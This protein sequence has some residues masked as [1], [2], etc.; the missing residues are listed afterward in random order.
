[1]T[2]NSANVELAPNHR[3]AESLCMCIHQVANVLQVSSTDENAYY[4]AGKTLA[5]EVLLLITV[6]ANSEEGNAKIIV[7]CEKLVIGSMMT[8]DIQHILSK[9][10]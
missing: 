1:M 8:K 7:N 5:S 10:A 3:T 6:Q 9:P 2:E 4:F